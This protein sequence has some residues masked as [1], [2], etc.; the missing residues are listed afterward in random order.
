MQIIVCYIGLKG[1]VGEGVGASIVM[2][3]VAESSTC[4]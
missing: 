2:V 3:A 1:Q 4:T